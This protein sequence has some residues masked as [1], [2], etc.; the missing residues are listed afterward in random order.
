LL[1]EGARSYDRQ[2]HYPRYPHETS[3][4]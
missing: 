2:D 3:Q 1:R 4:F